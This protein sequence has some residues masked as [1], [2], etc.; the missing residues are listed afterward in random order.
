MNHRSWRYLIF[1]FLVSPA[2]QAQD[3]DPKV[4]SDQYY[5][6]GMEVYGFTHRKEAKDLFIM[7][8]QY[9]PQNAKAYFMAGKSIMLTIQKQE[10][11]HYF[12]QAL[13]LDPQVDS[14]ILYYLGRAHHYTYSFDSAIHYYEAF[15]KSIRTLETGRN[16]KV[17]EADKRIAQ[18]RNAKI[19]T[20]NPVAVTIKDLNTAINSEWPDYAPAVT[21][22]ETY[23][24]FT[25]RRPD[26][27]INHEVADDHEYYEDIYFSVKENG[28][29]QPARNIGKNL[30]SKF[31]DAS[32]N[33]S[34]DGT[35]M[36]VYSDDN[37]GDILLSTREPGGEWS[38]PR[39]LQ[40]INTEYLENSASLSAD[41]QT[42]YFTSNRPGGHGGTDIYVATL[43]RN[44]RWGNVRNLGPVVNSEDDEDGVFISANGKHLY[45]SSNGHRGMGDLDIYRSTFD[46]ASGSWGTPA[47]LG[48]PI[49]SVENDIY[50]VLSA[51][52]QSAYISS[53]RSNNRHDNIG[54]QDIYYVDMTNW[55]EPVLDTPDVL[56]AQVEVVVDNETNI[57][58]DQKPV[59]VMAEAPEMKDEDTIN[60]TPPAF[61][62]EPLRTDPVIAVEREADK[63]SAAEQED[64]V[65]VTIE[66]KDESTGERIKATVSVIRES[67]ERLVF[68]SFGTG[69]YV[70]DVPERTIRDYGLSVTAEGYLPFTAISHFATLPGATYDYYTTIRLKRPEP[71]ATAILPIYF[72]LDSDI[73][74]S[75][76]TIRELLA[77]LLKNSGMRIEIAGH[78]DNSG[79]DEYNLDLSRRRAQ[80]VRTYLIN[81]GVKE[82]QVAAVGYGE[83]KP[84]ASNNTRASRKLNRRTEVRVIAN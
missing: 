54:E 34:T 73:P 58:D 38:K 23:M 24:V 79:P 65:S 72:G 4:L 37:G 40:G 19:Y 22:D 30:N 9:N 59:M 20:D 7:A 18:C 26:G 68:E 29:W 46:D 8:I 50:F 6:M 3:E 84:V 14:D 67:G 28:E 5:K 11:L 17:R 16:T 66:T 2:L 36:L 71:E 44:G 1:L 31:H 53:V 15:K 49:N 51:D 13:S 77:M 62:P 56:S 81:R 43:G 80:A 10:A 39:T 78:T 60:I 75:W 69:I 63:V 57:A 32:I 55:R 61:F 42:L 83:T 82:D 74:D 27:N 76:E 41:G 52:E 12:Q 45:F 33:I 25:S 21:G 35:Q 64:M 48:Y 70:L 47:N